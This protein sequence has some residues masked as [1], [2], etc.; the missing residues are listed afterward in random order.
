M[1]GWCP[2]WTA[3]AHFILPL[4]LIMVAVMNLTASLPI[5]AP[6]LTR[7]SA[8]ADTLLALN[9]ANAQELSWLT[10]E[11]LSHIIGESFRAQ[12]IGD[13]DAFLLALDQ[14]ANYDSPNFIW[15]REYYPRFVYVDRIVVASSARGHGLARR[16]YE[17]V[18][19]QAVDAGHDRV[20][21]EV[22]LIPP[23]PGSDAFHAS[24]GFAEVGRAD[25]KD[26]TVRYLARA[27]TDGPRR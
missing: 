2:F 25:V 8:L 26:R 20:F 23:N 27:L 16:L 10:P 9:N 1:R 19:T 12:R 13:V 4:V 24:M 18:F 7:A 17:D 21:C 14:D 15:F 22:N 5:T 11:R 3:S 6:E